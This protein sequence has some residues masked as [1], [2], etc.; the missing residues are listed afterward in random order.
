MDEKHNID[1]LYL[2]T[3]EKH[4]YLIEYLNTYNINVFSIDN[5]NKDLVEMQYHGNHTFNNRIEKNKFTKIVKK[6][7]MY[8]EEITS[9]F[10]LM[11][12]ESEK[13]II[14]SKYFNTKSSRVILLAHR[15]LDPNYVKYF[16]R[17]IYGSLDNLRYKLEI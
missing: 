5:L 4:P 15:K 2:T 13:K 8:E 12:N 3:S 16:L 7:N 9:S 1:M 6:K 11:N 17:N 14:G 10:K